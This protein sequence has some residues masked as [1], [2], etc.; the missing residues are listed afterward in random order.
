MNKPVDLLYD[1][2][3]FVGPLNESE[4]KHFE[5][6]LHESGQ[7]EIHFEDSYLQ[8]LKNFHGGKPGRRYF[9]TALGT[10]HV[11]ERFL[12]FLPSGSNHPLE[13][14]SVEATWSMIDDRLGKYLMPFAELFAGDYLC[15]DFTKG[16]RPEIVVWFHEL[17]Q[18]NRPHTEFVSKNFDEFLNLLSDLP[19]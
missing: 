2:T 3:T 4:A 12:N 8:H 10:D 18:P 19:S 17:S 5:K 16:G 1:P 15:F 7:E 6:W 14:Y 11:V 13:E 9:R